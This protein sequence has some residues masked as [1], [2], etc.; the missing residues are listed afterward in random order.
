MQAGMDAAQGRAA[1]LIDADL[2]HPPELIPRMLQLWK[3]GYEIVNAVK[4]DRGKESWIYRNLAQLFNR[5]LTSAI[6]QHDLQGASDYK[7]LDREVL[8]ALRQCSERGRFLRGLVAWV[9]FEQI[10]IEFDVAERPEG[11]TKWSLTSLAIYTLRNLLAF[12][13]MPLRLVAVMGFLTVAAGVILAIQTLVVYLSGEAISGFTTTILLLVLF[14]GMIL[15]SLGVI[16]SYLA[17]MFDEQKARP[18]YI[19]RKDNNRKQATLDHSQ[20]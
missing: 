13:S 6:G 12:S 14:S 17:L 3:A 10:S 15:S 9:G 4:A 5:L 11:R 8:N 1:V 7:L 2:Q 16:A 20:G 18:L 19:V